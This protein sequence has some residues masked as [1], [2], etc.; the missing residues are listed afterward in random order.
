[1]RDR[2]GRVI[3]R[4][5]Q[6][7]VARLLLEEH[8]GAVSAARHDRGLAHELRDDVVQVERRAQLLAGGE[9]L[10]QVPM[11][12][13]N[14]TRGEPEAELQ[15]H[16]ERRVHNGD[17][18]DHRSA[19]MRRSS[20]VDAHPA[21]SPAR[22]RRRSSRP[23]RSACRRP[24]SRAPSPARRPAPP[25][26]SSSRHRCPP[27]TRPRHPAST[28]ARRG[29][30][31]KG[32]GAVRASS[33]ARALDDRGAPMVAGLN[34]SSAAR[35]GPPTRRSALRAAACCSEFLTMCQP[36]NPDSPETSAAASTLITPKRRAICEVEP[37]NRTSLPHQS[38]VP[39]QIVGRTPAGWRCGGSR[40]GR[41]RFDLPSRPF[42]LRRPHVRRGTWRTDRLLSCSRE[43]RA[44]GTAA[45]SSATW[46]RLSSRSPRGWT[47]LSWPP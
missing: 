42:P 20:R 35:T 1:M 6:H 9:E 38:Q 8:D 16:A 15:Q 46:G 18:E 30:R 2:S 11:L 27:D 5:A 47:A 13:R 23:S 25:A 17:L 28:G 32:A 12:C 14:G 40:I 44:C 31:T 33:R 3:V 26:A 24:P 45:E 36:S 4:R 22:S 21:R 34:R 37:P 41:R 19:A 39:I 29:G 7:H 43:S 10:R